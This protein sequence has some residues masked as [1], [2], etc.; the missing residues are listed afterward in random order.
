MKKI[1]IPIMMLILAGCS[2]SNSPT[3]QDDLFIYSHST[4]IVMKVIT[5]DGLEVPENEWK[6]V[7]QQAYK[8]YKIEV[9]N[10]KKMDIKLEDDTFYRVYKGSSTGFPYR[11]NGDTVIVNMLEVEDDSW[12]VNQAIKIDD[13]TIEQQYV[14]YARQQE[15]GQSTLS[16][17]FIGDAEKFQ[18]LF[19][20]RKP[21]LKEGEQ[22]AVFFERLIY[23]KK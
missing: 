18:V 22:I 19:D 13:N 5:K 9:E 11:M 3:N 6:S 4:D 20:N 14:S 23:E 17:N 16:S 7:I 1:L 15:L 12:E 10:F 2:D 21:T 8:D